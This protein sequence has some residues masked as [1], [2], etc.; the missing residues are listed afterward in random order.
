MGVS[1]DL[2]VLPD[3]EMTG[4]AADVDAVIRVR[5]VADD[6]LVLLVEGVHRTPRERSQAPRPAVSPSA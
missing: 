5:G 4:G 3:E 1:N 2:V 6:P